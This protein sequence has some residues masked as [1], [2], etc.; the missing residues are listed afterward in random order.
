MGQ[1]H[2]HYERPLLLAPPSP[3]PL[4]PPLPPTSTI[5]IADDTVGAEG[6][7]LECVPA[8]SVSAFYSVS[9]ICL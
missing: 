9:L 2:L 8:S 6:G 4:L 7:R 5:V 1:G 3:F